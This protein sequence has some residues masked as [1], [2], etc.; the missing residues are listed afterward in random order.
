MLMGM[1]DGTKTNV[2]G[3]KPWSNDNPLTPNEAYFT[4]LDAVLQIV[5]MRCGGGVDFL[6]DRFEWKSRG[7]AGPSAAQQVHLGTN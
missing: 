7:F 6:Y 2:Y 5:W 3:R 4:N 1:G